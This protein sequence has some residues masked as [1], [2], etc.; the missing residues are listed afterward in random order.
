MFLLL[1][2]LPLVDALPVRETWDLERVKALASLAGLSF[3]AEYVH[4]VGTNGKGSTS[5]FLER[6]LREQGH[7]VGLYT[8]PHLSAYNERILLQGKNVSDN[9][10]LELQK[11]VAPLLQKMKKA[12][13]PPSPFEAF[14]VLALQ[15]F[16]QERADLVVLE[17]GL[18]GRLDATNVCPG[19]TTILTS[20][21][22]DH[23]E[24]LGHTLE[25]IAKEKVGVVKRNAS[26]VNG[27]LQPVVV[28]TV[29][30][31]CQKRFARLY[32]LGRDFSF[33]NVQCTEKQTTF[34]Y[35]GLH[36]S[37][38]AVSLSLLGAHQSHNASCSLAALECLQERGFPVSEASQRQGLQRTHW[39]ARL[40]ILQEKPLV[41]V[42]GAHNVHGVEAL[43]NALQH[44][45]LKK[46]RRLF[47]VFGV[48]ADK[49][50]EEMLSEL[51]PLAFRVVLTTPESDRALPPEKLVPFLERQ[52]VSC[53]VCPAIPGALDAALA[54]AS[55]ND[56]VLVAGSLYLV[57][58]ARQRLIKN[59]RSMAV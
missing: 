20:V 12:G 51:A 35:A 56:M 29:A 58:P 31:V 1:S 34:D 49:A 41:V 18:G 48:L 11:E 46:G 44:I 6:M 2:R 27:A 50:Y 3:P 5:A 13:K 23:T 9:R 47:L 30:S 57:G 54:L 38:S 32:S 52:H 40:E 45:F 10:L 4:V 33:S 21:A 17:A 28:K 36:H 53:Q 43:K 25:D 26:V 8:S 16:E 55:P 7:R 15:Y 37:L 19:K 59:P 39:P 42:D 14:T 24:Y 22:F